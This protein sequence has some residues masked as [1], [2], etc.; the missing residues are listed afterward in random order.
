MNQNAGVD[1]VGHMGYD[2]WGTKGMLLSSYNG[3]GE[4][5]YKC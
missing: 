4:F 1:L 2:S 5:S 3:A